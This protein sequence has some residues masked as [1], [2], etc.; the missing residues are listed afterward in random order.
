MTRNKQGVVDYFITGFKLALVLLLGFLIMAI[1]RILLLL[2]FVFA[3][4][5]GVVLWI[6]SVAAGLTVDGWLVTKYKRFIFK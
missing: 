1:P 2:Q 4:W 6:V 3:P 5:L